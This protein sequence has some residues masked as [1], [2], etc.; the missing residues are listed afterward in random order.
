[1]Y[2]RNNLLISSVSHSCALFFYVKVT[3]NLE[4]TVMYVLPLEIMHNYC[5]KQHKVEN[6]FEMQPRL[7]TI[8]V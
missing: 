1:M 8:D 4:N 2:P 6:Y 7:R 5:S 3:M